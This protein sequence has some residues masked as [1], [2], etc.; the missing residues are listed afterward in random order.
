MADLDALGFVPVRSSFELERPGDTSDLPEPR[1]GPMASCRC[2]SGS[3]STTRNS[4]QMLY[5]FWADVPGHTDRPIEEW[6]SSILAGPWFDADLVVIARGDGGIGPIVGVVL[7]RTFTGGVGWVSQLGVARS[8]RGLGL[9]PGGP[10]RVVSAPRREGAEDH[11]PRCRGRERQCARAVSQC[12]LRD[13]P[14]MDPLFTNVTAS[15]A[16][17][18]R[19][20]VPFGEHPFG[21]VAQLARA[22][23]LQAGGRGFDSHRL[24]H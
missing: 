7:G 17:R 21:D 3:E 22:P 15:V 11:R 14:G 16:R 20:A 23:A 5:D 1:R 18:Y 8:A 2:R 10:D 4:T 9:G 24:H 12:R 6:R 13:L 19:G